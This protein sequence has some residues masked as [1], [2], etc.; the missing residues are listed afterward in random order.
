MTDYHKLPDGGYVCEH[1]GTKYEGSFARQEV[2]QCCQHLKLKPHQ[3]IQE[4]DQTAIDYE[5][6]LEN[7]EYERTPEREPARP[8][9]FKDYEKA[10]ARNERRGNIQDNLANNKET[11]LEIERHLCEIDKLA[12][13]LPHIPAKYYKG[14]APPIKR[15]AGAFL[16]HNFEGVKNAARD[17]GKSNKPHPE[18]INFCPYC[19]RPIPRSPGAAPEQFHDT[20]GPF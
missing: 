6:D 10:Q 4:A 18:T 7:Q 13:N 1:C 20:G 11:E 14:S 5:S 3:A 12:A 15:L 9:R 17:Y 16:S 8:R 2:I 19:G